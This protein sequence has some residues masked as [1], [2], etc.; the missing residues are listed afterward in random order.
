MYDFTNEF[1]SKI[2]ALL[3]SEIQLRHPGI[4]VEWENVSFKQPKSGR[5]FSIC[6]AQN[7]QKQTTIG[8]K[9]IVRTTGFVQFDVLDREETD[10][11]Y[12]AKKMCESLT[13]ILAYRKFKGENI[14]VV[15]GDKHVMKPMKAN[16]FIR[17]TGRVFFHYDG[18]R[19]RETV[20]AL[21]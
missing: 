16:E 1:D 17:V 18:E 21:S 14:N 4:P 9:F 20:Q 3:M 5:W 15:F 12:W 6:S 2:D 13:D 10:D 11:K 8:R 7:P 19:I